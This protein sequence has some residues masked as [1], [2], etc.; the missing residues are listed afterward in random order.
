MTAIDR[1]EETALQKGLLGE[2]EVARR[3]PT[4]EEGWFVINSIPVSMTGTD[5]DH[6]A[7]GP[8]GVFSLNTKNH[9][10][11]KIWLGEW[12]LL[13]NGHK[14]DYLRA[15]RNEGLK[16]SRILSKA[17]GFEIFAKPVIVII[18]DADDWTIKGEPKDVQVESYQ[19]VRSWLRNQPVTLT[20]EQVLSIHKVACKSE[21]WLTSEEVS[22]APNSISP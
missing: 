13:V 14:Q 21:T 9:F 17:C 16:V 8:G 12:A 10:G 3:L 6:L 20:S 18:A 5:I 15:S 22:K 11:S 19:T 7:I 1:F 4:H 2:M